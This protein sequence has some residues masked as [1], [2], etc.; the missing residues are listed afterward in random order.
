MELF[1]WIWILENQL[2]YLAAENKESA[3]SYW[4]RIDV[5][6]CLLV[7]TS[8]HPCKTQFLDFIVHASALQLE[9]FLKQYRFGVTMQGAT[10]F[11][12]R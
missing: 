2:Q 11:N 8:T 9:E 7:N 4:E 3:N 10:W 5:L 1:A 12:S 6:Y